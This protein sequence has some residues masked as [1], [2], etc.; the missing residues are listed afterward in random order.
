[1]PAPSCFFFNPHLRF[2]G[3]VFKPTLKITGLRFIRQSAAGEKHFTAKEEQKQNPTA[4]S[5][6]KRR[7]TQE[8]QKLKYFSRVLLFL[9]I[10]AFSALSAVGFAFALPLRPLRPL[11]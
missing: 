6:E 10:S 3:R 5:A 4:E 7:E 8:K 11:R 1:M 2:C 9:C